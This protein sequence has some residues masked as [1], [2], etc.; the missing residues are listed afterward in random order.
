MLQFLIPGGSFSVCAHN[1]AAV[2]Q[3]ARPTSG[4]YMFS[5]RKFEAVIINTDYLIFALLAYSQGD[6]YWMCIFLCS[7]SVHE[8]LLACWFSNELNS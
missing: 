4:V 3:C 7:V 6:I 1:R 2:D 8:S 5:S